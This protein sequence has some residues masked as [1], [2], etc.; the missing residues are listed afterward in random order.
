MRLQ[1]ILETTG[2]I[3][4][5]RQSMFGRIIPNPFPQ[6]KITQEMYHGSRTAG[7]MKF[8]RPRE[9]LWFAEYPEW[10]QEHYIPACGDL[11]VCWLDVKNPYIPTEDELDDYYGEMDII[12]DFFDI[13]KEKGYDAYIQGGESGSIAVFDTVKVMNAIT[14]KIM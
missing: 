2:Y 12:G 14:G 6:S 4:K 11:Y 3:T 13:L 9:G 10:C 1:D 5:G 8:S 7:L